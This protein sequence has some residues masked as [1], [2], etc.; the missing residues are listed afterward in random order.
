MYLHS[1][2]DPKATISFGDL[3]RARLSV[4]KAIDA[5][6]DL[7]SLYTDLNIIGGMLRMDQARLLRQ[8]PPTVISR[9]CLHES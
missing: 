2:E 7:A 1:L 8:G 6:L 4:V 9:R 3:A 5:Y